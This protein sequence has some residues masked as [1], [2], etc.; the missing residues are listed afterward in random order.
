MHSVYKVNIGLNFIIF[1][2]ANLIIVNADFS[3]L[4]SPAN[5]ATVNAGFNILFFPAHLLI[6]NAILIKS[7]TLEVVFMTFFL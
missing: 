7:Y 2:P 6:V 1:T 4:F 3:I 5:L